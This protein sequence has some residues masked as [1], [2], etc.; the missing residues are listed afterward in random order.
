MGLC[1]SLRLLIA[2][3][4]IAIAT[5]CATARNNFLDTVAQRILPA[6]HPSL[7]DS[8][9]ASKLA[10]ADQTKDA[11]VRPTAGSQEGAASAKGKANDRSNELPLAIEGEGNKLEAKRSSSD[12]SLAPSD[13]DE[14]ALEAIAASGR[15]LTLPEAISLAFH[16]QPRLRTSSRALP[17]L[18]GSSKSPSRR[19]CPSSPRTTTSA[20]SVSESEAIQSRSGR[21]SQGSISCQV[22]ER[23]QLVSTSERASN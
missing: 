4:S 15:P 22:W 18:A 7:V 12:A 5:G 21:V 23:F 3:G 16:H 10:K 20:D 11:M 17:R 1:R 9:S 2:L 8:D 19:F 13:S 14:A 6:D